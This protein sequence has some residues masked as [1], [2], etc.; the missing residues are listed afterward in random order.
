MTIINSKAEDLVHP[1]QD[2][3]AQEAVS[4][5]RTY[6]EQRRRIVA[7]AEPQME[8]PVEDGKGQYVDVF[9]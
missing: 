1:L 9:A 8:R 5:W 4:A 2:G 6:E 7:E 3:R